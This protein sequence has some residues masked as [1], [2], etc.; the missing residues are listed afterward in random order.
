MKHTPKDGW[1]SP[2]F[3]TG[4]R[5]SFC[6]NKIINTNH[7][8]V[9]FIVGHG[10]PDLEQLSLPLNNSLRMQQSFYSNHHTCCLPQTIHLSSKQFDVR[11]L[12]QENVLSLVTLMLPMLTG[13]I[14]PNL[15]DSIKNSSLLQK[16][17]HDHFYFIKGMDVTK[18]FTG[19]DGLS[20]LPSNMHLGSYRPF[21]PI[22]SSWP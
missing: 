8:D 1:G 6:L 4:K 21:T 9:S 3:L 16:R 5:G 19:P 22:Y 14:D 2:K 10:V 13:Q 17:K 18:S 12:P 20:S 15:M 7:L 11:P